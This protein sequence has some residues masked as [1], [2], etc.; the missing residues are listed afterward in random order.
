MKPNL[1]DQEIDVQVEK[2]N[3]DLPFPNAIN[4]ANTVE[5][6][7]K[8]FMNLSNVDSLS[9]R[10]TEEESSDYYLF[11]GLKTVIYGKKPRVESHTFKMYKKDY[12]RKVRLG[13]QIGI[14][15]QC[16][17]MIHDADL[18]CKNKEALSKVKKPRTTKTKTN[19]SNDKV[20]TKVINDLDK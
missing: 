9:E 1:L 5:D 2:Y 17:I 10:I 6:Y 7:L 16:W 14:G 11:V 15:Y 3:Q 18:E 8:V 20:D 13:N 12:N 19:A 4:N